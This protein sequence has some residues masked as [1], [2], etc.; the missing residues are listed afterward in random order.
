MQT[1]QEEFI[2]IKS[3]LGCIEAYSQSTGIGCAVSDSE[4]VVLYQYGFCCSDCAVC[5][6]ADPKETGPGM[7][8]RAA[9]ENANVEGAYTHLCP[10]GLVSI[11]SAISGPN[12]LV[13][14][15]TAGPFLTSDMGME[16]ENTLTFGSGVNFTLEGVKFNE[17][18]ESFGR[19]PRIPPGRV[20]PLSKLLSHLA[21][22][23]SGAVSA[24]KSAERKI[25]FEP[26]RQPE[27]NR[28]FG[29]NRRRGPEYPIDTEKKLLKSIAESDVLRVKKL[30]NEL[31]GHLLLSQEEDF[32]GMKSGIYD[33]LVV[34]SRGAIDA[35]V[36][37]GKILQMNKQLWWQ[38]QLV[39]GINDLCVLLADVVN[40]YMDSILD[41]STKRNTD[42][43]YSAMR[44][45][46]RNYS[47]K[48]SLEDVAKAVY[49]AP[50]YLS[51]VFKKEVGCN[52]NEYL[53]QLRIEK[54]KELLSLGGSRIGDVMAT[55]GFDDPSYFTKVFKRVAGVSPKYFRKSS[56]VA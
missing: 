2:N 33:L 7:A 31:L 47:K 21:R 12:G 10:G 1:T 3:I 15:I 19:I 35:G 45:I 23:I 11:S 42:V 20:M 34:I 51:K 26:F 16:N 5:G 28:V 36:P 22:N 55:V 37:R 38:V 27:A 25:G 54:S 39:Q 41:Y 8:F 48:I 49:L 17:I 6:T 53:N 9:H 24:D 50:T 32:E 40:K 46:S 13:A 56:E 18:A 29:K 52:F 4:G 44:F 30:L 14:D 43:I